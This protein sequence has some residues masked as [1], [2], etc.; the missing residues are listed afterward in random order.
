MI[1]FIERFIPNKFLAAVV[2]LIAYFF[3]A[4]V[5][6][7][8]IQKVFI[9]LTLKTK[10]DLDD[11]I[12]AAIHHPVS[13]LLV[14]I[15]IQQFII[16]MD[17]TDFFNRSTAKTLEFVLTNLVNSLMILIVAIILIRLLSIFVSYFG[18]KIVRRT[19]SQ[20]DNQMLNLFKKFLKIIL[21]LFAFF[22]IL[23]QWNF[24]VIPYLTGIGIAG[25]AIGLA[26]KDS[27]A[28]I[29]GG[30]TV[31]LD[32]DIRIGDKIR[33]ESGVIGVVHDIGLISTK[34]KTFDNEMVIIPNGQLS[35]QLIHNYALPNPLNRVFVDFS[36]AYGTDLKKLDKVV[37]KVI[38]EINVAIKDKPKPYLDMLEMADSGLNF[39]A[40]FYVKDYR[41]AYQAKVDATRQIYE[42][43][44]AENIEIPFPQMDVHIKKD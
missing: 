10:T 14:S 23:N 31:I 6:L 1:E 30:I 5:F 8:I 4:K 39:S 9:K 35:T 19:K 37:Y 12:I 13:F 29:F 2:I 25:I 11:K 7:W 22:Y 15:G 20:H 32:G 16:R 42:S 24:N 33:L 17:F 43:L 38:S 41:E 3:L 27:L 40:R 34:M 26:V 21:Y 44:M 18:N 28:N 36:V